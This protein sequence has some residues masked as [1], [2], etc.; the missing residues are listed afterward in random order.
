M[1]FGYLHVGLPKSCVQF[2]FGIPQGAGTEDYVVEQYIS[3][4]KPY[5]FKRWEITHPRKEAAGEEED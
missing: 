3:S 5:E 4:D 1:F 2:C